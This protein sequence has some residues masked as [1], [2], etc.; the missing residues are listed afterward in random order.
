MADPIMDL[1]DDPNLFTLDPFP[2]DPS[3][4]RD[5]VAEALG[6]SGALDPPPDPAPRDP[7]PDPGESKRITLVLQQPPGGANTPPGQRHVVLGSLPGKIVLQGNQLAALSQA[8][9]TPGQPAKVV[10]IQLQVQQPPGGQGA[11]QK[12][13]L[14][15][16]GGGSGQ[17][18]PVTVSSV[19]QVVGGAGQRLTVPL[20]VVLQ[21]QVRAWGRDVVPNV[22]LHPTLGH[23]HN[24]TLTLSHTH[25]ITPVVGKK[26]KRNAS[27]DTSDTEVLPAPSPREEEE[28]SVQKRRSNRQVKRKKYTEDLDIK[29]TDDEEDE[30]LD[31]TG[32]IRPEQPPIPQPPIPEPEPEGET[33]PSMQFFVE[34]PS[35][36]D[37]AIVDKVLSMRVV[38][39]ELPSGQLIESEEFFVKY[40]NYSYLHCEWATIDQ[41]EKDKRI[42][43]KLKRFKTKMTQMR[44]FFHE[45]EEPFNPDYVEVDRILDESHSV[46]KD[47]GEPVVYYLVKWCSLPYEDSTWELKEDVDEAKVGDFKRIQARPPDLKRLARPQAGAWKKLE[48]SHEYKNHN[49]LREYQLEGVNWLLF[50][51]YNRQNCILA[52]EMGLGKTIQSIAF[53]QEVFK[54]GIRGPFL[55]IAPLSTIT[56]WERE[57]NTWT[58]MNTIVYHGSLASR[59][60]I[61]QYEMY[62]KDPRGR[63]IPGA[64]KFD[65]L[66]TTFEMILSDCPELREIEWRCVII[67]EAHRLKN[68]NCK[69][70]D[71][72]KHMDLEH[73]VL[74]TGTPL[75]NTVEE[76]FSLLHF[77]EP[78]QFPSEAEFLKDFGDLKTEEQVQKLQAILKPMMLRRLKEDVEKNLAP[79][80]ET[81]IEVELT[82][83]Q[84]KYY[85]A[86]LEKNFSFLSKGAGHT[87]MPNLLNTMME[88]RKCCNHPYLI[89]G[90]EEK[91]LAEFR[92]SCHHHVPHDFHLQ[93]MVRSAGKLVLI[94]KLLPKLKAGGHKV[95]I[96][97]QMVRCLDILEDYLIQ[98]RYL[99]ERIDG[100]VRGN[101]RQAAID[102]FSRPD[103]DRC[104][105]GEPG[106]GARG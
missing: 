74:L 20:K 17:A 42:H 84:K 52:D 8:K 65:A 40:K 13:Q 44:H 99:Y 26:R 43:Q 6:L 3:R 16:Q 36:E 101:L 98:K 10:T 47:N 91:I 93:A 88:L 32:P 92:D 104:G 102:R 70:L 38:K 39:K 51:W 49:Q 23:T 21:P 95:L 73:K 24:H 97:S 22:G 14:L 45:D 83:I 7:S 72:L 59:Q 54:V 18:T 82:N 30:E 5:P 81:I 19:P 55:V 2:D 85:R 29:I 53:L 4:S 77:L 94:D 1:F 64:Y 86:I 15:Q 79:K 63:L 56:N 28:T 11:P 89:N 25:T 103:S 90:A 34:N 50:N 96:F 37:A 35:E 57:F 71:S 105:W 27:S 66:I 67:D 33:L 106:G 60:M 41:L 58:E 68:R 48:M 87:N 61:Q 69:L 76:L 12:I 75:Q 46:D 31:V 100:R 62:C 80:Q 78:S 9:G